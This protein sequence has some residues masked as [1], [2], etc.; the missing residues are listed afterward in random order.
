MMMLKIAWRNI[1]RN[2]TR[3][4]VI[5][6]AVSVGIWAALF[7]IAFSWGMSAQ[8]ISDAIEN[9]LGH[10]QVHHPQF[11]DE[12]QDLKYR[13][14]NGM[15]LAADLQRDPRVKVATARLV[16]PALAASSVTSSGVELDG[17]VPE[18]EQLLTHLDQKL[19]EGTYFEDIRR[20]P[21]IISSKLADM[22]DVK[23][24]SKIVLSFQ[25]PEKNIVAAAFRVV[26]V[27]RSAN[28]G[29]DKLHVFVRRS[30]LQ[31][32]VN[33]DQMV[34]EV[35]V[36]LNS[37]DSVNGVLS[38]FRKVHPDVQAE[39]WADLAPDLK[40]LNSAFDQGMQIFVFIIMMALAFGI[41]NTMLMAVLER[42]RE[43]GILMAVGMN[44]GRVFRMIMLETILLSLCGA[45]VGI[46][47]AWL[48]I[49]WFGT[50]GIDLAVVGQGLESFGY[51]SMVYPSIASHFYVDI[52]VQVFVVAVLA[53]IYPAL[54]A[55]RLKPV[56]AI[57][58]I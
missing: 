36:K 31:A 29:Y 52:V 45:P 15:Q 14:E 43:L 32:L 51:G 19:K 39:S 17:I 4:L 40:V 35:A 2:R 11:R 28:S 44:K 7:L 1:W 42:I 3:S 12:D 8:R 49:Y 6:G 37:L 53:A 23:L 20:N 25:G 58:K 48:S 27:Y 9:Q 56:E 57:R 41:V 10:F 33:D 34:D 24:R 50:H 13:L 55:L 46:F 21:V 18:E 38:D 26:G 47:V 22:L 54:K 5:V 30:D 16:V